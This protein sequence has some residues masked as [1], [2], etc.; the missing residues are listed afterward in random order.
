MLKKKTPIYR[1]QH[2]LIGGEWTDAE[3]NARGSI[4]NLVPEFP[5]ASPYRG[6]F[7]V[8]Q[9][10]ANKLNLLNTAHCEEEDEMARNS[11]GELLLRWMKIT[12]VPGEEEKYIA[13]P[14]GK[15]VTVP[16]L[17]DCRIYSDGWFY[18]KMS[19]VE[20]STGDITF[21]DE[22]LGEVKLRFDLVNTPQLPNESLTTGILPLATV[23]TNSQGNIEEIIQQQFGP[24]VLWVPNNI[25]EESSSS[26]SSSSG[27]SSSE[28]P[29][30]SSSSGHPDIPV[31]PPE[32]SSSSTNEDIIIQVTL[33][34]D[35]ICKGDFVGLGVETHR[36]NMLLT[37]SFT[38]SQN[39][40]NNGYTV[41]MT[42]SVVK[43][44][45]DGSPITEEVSWDINIFRNED[46]GH[47]DVY[48]LKVIDWAGYYQSQSSE[49]DIDFTTPVYIFP[50][51]Q[52]ML[53]YP[54]GI[55]QVDHH[56]IHG[57]SLDVPDN[58]LTS[59]LQITFTRQ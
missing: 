42:G 20:H 59:S 19:R 36:Y 46:A 48:H 24:G 13:Q 57:A 35:E 5:I 26:G 21:Q 12:R 38:A 45:G 40:P 11:S 43:D 1:Q 44:Y 15:T 10:D 31:N 32:D 49:D 2:N 58:D 25:Q 17:S 51:L 30:F 3:N 47:W 50:D 23:I 14:R 16:H 29:D 22:V 37:G 6:N 53:T 41:R 4:I 54:L 39:Y 27:S 55:I 34:Y 52:T 9:T 28:N 8:V 33:Q 7:Q 18:L 56:L